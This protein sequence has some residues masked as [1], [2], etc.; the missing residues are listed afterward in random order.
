MRVNGSNPLSSESAT[1]PIKSRNFDFCGSVY[2]C[3][4]PIVCL[5]HCVSLPIVDYVKTVRV[6]EEK[7]II[8]IKAPKN[9]TSGSKVKAI[10]M[11]KVVV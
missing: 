7:K 3:V 11:T 5:S 8:K 4:P 1:R 10:L 6:S 9:C 2:M